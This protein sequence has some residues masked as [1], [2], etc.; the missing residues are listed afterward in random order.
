MFQ[1]DYLVRMIEQI[2]E[3]IAAITGASAAGR[4]DEAERAIDQLY[5]THLGLPRR[6]LTALD[7]GSVVALIGRDKVPALRRILEAERDVCAARG[8]A[9]AEGAVRRRLEAL[10]GLVS[11]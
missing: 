5:S 8:D 4:H 3:A 7:A 9:A 6:T 2:A 1:R 11:R 10:E